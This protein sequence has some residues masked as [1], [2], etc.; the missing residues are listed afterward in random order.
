M[1]TRLKLYAL[2]FDLLPKRD[3]LLNLHFFQLL[4]PDRPP[5]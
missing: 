4:D 2:T 5:N 1:P 3:I